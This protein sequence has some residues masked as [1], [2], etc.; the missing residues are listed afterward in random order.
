MTDEQ[1]KVLI[2]AFLPLCE[3][4]QEKRPERTREGFSW[5]WVAP[6]PRDRLSPK[7]GINGGG[8]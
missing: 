3:I 5:I 2:G 8:E 4:V 1:I 7:R 6:D